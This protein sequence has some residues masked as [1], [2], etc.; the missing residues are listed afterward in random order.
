[1]YRTAAGRL[2]DGGLFVQWLPLY[3]L[4]REEFEVIARTFLAAFPHVTLWRNDFYPNRP[5][6]G[7]VGARRPL[8]ID[9][10]RLGARLAGLPAWGRDSLL[11]APRALGMLYVAD[12]GS[13]AGLL[14]AGPLTS[15]DR[16]LLEFLAPRLTRM[17]ADGDK[18]WLR[19]AALADYTEALAARA[20][21]ADDATLPPT[22]EMAEARRAGAALFR[23]A[24]AATSG[25]AAQADALMREVG[26]LVPDVIA[27]ADREAPSV[28]LADVRRNL[29]R[30]R[31]EQERLRQQLQS[32]E[33][34]LGT[35]TPAAGDGR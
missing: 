11:A 16:P 12:L 6:L 21:S 35:G 5:V 31:S 22:G 24:I 19:G 27:S 9:L 33:Q 23:Y 32:M 28:E 17:G 18:D 26:R 13:R 34:R 10:E 15:D 29:G 8:R 7:L 4:S 1:M 14:P 25:N 2:A 30:L 3:Q 20:T